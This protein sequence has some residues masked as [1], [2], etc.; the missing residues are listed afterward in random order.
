[1]GTAEDIPEILRRRE[2][3]KKKNK[4]EDEDLM[5]DTEEVEATTVINYSKSELI[6]LLEE[7]KNVELGVVLVNYRPALVSRRKVPHK[8]GETSGERKLQGRR[9]QTKKARN[10]SDMRPGEG[11]NSIGAKVGRKRK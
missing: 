6:D 4:V 8:E 3:V 2:D 10:M 7:G 11:N 5:E 9:G 1:M